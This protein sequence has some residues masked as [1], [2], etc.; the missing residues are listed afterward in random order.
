MSEMCSAGLDASPPTNVPVNSLSTGRLSQPPSLPQIL[1]D[2]QHLVG[3][4]PKPGLPALGQASEGKPCT[5]QR[6]QLQ[7]CTKVSSLGATG[8][9][10]E[11]A[12]GPSIPASVGKPTERQLQP[13]QQSLVRRQQ[14]AGTAPGSLCDMPVQFRPF[15]AQSVARSW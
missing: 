14:R 3:R 12:A 13:L 11:C 7:V 2:S 9:T 15:R 1:L 6:Q 4:S 5:E 10:Q 8:L